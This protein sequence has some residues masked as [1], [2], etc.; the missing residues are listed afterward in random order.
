MSK[1]A[2]KQSSAVARIGPLR[3]YVRRAT[4]PS[5]SNLPN[6][7]MISSNIGSVLKRTPKMRTANRPIFR[8][9][10]SEIQTRNKIV[11]ASSRATQESLAVVFTFGFRQIRPKSP[12]PDRKRKL[13]DLQRHRLHRQI[14]PK[15]SI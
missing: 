6:L 12:F 2:P 7:P 8:E 1:V 11:F 9:R 3:V 5:S 10:P 4:I 14:S 15:Y 13:E